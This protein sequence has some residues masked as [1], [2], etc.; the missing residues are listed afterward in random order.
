MANENNVFKFEK[1]KFNMYN[2]NGFGAIHIMD[3]WYMIL[4]QKKYVFFAVILILLIGL[5]VIYLLTPIYQA[6]AKVVVDS[7]QSKLVGLDVETVAGK[8]LD[9][10]VNTEVEIIKSNK[11][12]LR[13]V[14]HL[15]LWNAADY[16]EQSLMDK[17]LWL[18]V[19]EKTENSN[20]DFRNYNE[21][22]GQDLM[23]YL[24]ALNENISVARTQGTNVIEI[25]AVS[26]TAERAADIAN[27]IARSYLTEKV[28]SKAGS[29]REAAD[30]L[31]N[32]LNKLSEEIQN[33]EHQVENFIQEHS[34][35]VSSE[36]V[37]IELERLRTEII[38]RVDAKLEKILQLSQIGRASVTNDYLLLTQLS[39]GEEAESLYLKYEEV[40]QLLQV[41]T[42]TDNDKLSL[43]QE[44]LEIDENFASLASNWRDDLNQGINDT[45]A[46][47]DKIRTLRERLFSSQDLPQEVSLALYG[48]T[49]DIDSKRNLYETESTKYNEIEQKIGI[50]IPDV[51]V[52]AT[53]FPSDIPIKPNKKLLVV[54]LLV[55][56]VF[57]GLVLAVIR[58]KFIGG[59]TSS[60][61]VRSV[62]GIWPTSVIPKY[63]D[64]DEQNIILNSPLSRFSESIR[65]LRVGL[66]NYSVEDDEKSAKVIA[67]TSTLPQEDKTTTA[68]S[69][70]RSYA[71]AGAKT[72]LMDLDFRHPA[73]YKRLGL[74]KSYGLQDFIRDDGKISAIK[75]IIYNEEST[76][77]DVA[78]S[79]VIQK[80][81]TDILIQSACL[82]AVLNKFKSKYDVIVIDTPPVGLVVDMQII[83]QKVDLVVYAI[84]HASTSRKNVLTGVNSIHSANEEL[85]ILTIITQQDDAQASYYGM[86]GAEYSN[87]Y[88]G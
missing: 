44:L 72:I 46:K 3:H 20:S 58:D 77:L 42:L 49:T 43:Q 37:R 64:V 15:Q 32:Q 83:A 79:G 41:P 86:F 40:S 27:D 57:A 48:L 62:L 55:F 4:R 66:D 45:Q 10:K 73:V 33:H 88:S 71:M 78:L 75:N 23:G 26:T 30:V 1:P 13:T 5:P 18:F 69:L 67:V 35:K 76:G 53:A 54:G 60:E 59:F 7:D 47:I 21:L 34:G 12:H 38:T 50:L 81:A 11:V 17:F 65:M 87:Y 19:T 82:D 61:Q 31:R 8:S 6:T 28:E 51:R 39:G 84:G 29:V 63:D 25:S 80:T 68:L 22:S 9:Y 70:A 74:A 85:P 56:A 52:I 36:A 16:N 2:M 24:K 14:R